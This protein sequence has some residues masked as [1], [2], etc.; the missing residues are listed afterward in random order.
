[1]LS[2]LLPIGNLPKRHTYERKIYAKA[3][4]KVFPNPFDGLLA[5]PLKIPFRTELL[6]EFLLIV[7][8]HKIRK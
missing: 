3:F 2:L 5:K 1:M 8:T 6:K 7:D 4:A